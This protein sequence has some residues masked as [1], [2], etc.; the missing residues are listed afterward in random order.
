VR[1]VDGLEYPKNEGENMETGELNSSD[2]AY[3]RIWNNSDRDRGFGVVYPTEDE[4]HKQVLFLMEKDD[5]EGNPRLGYSGHQVCN[6]QG[7]ILGWMIFGEY[8]A[9]VVGEWNPEW[10]KN[11][12]KEERD[13]RNL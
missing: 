4:Y 10:R 2:P 9:P 13:R 3:S 7:D 1:T 5:K 12:T 11:W 8:A 6:P